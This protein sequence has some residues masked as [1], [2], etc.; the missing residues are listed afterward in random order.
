MSSMPDRPVDGDSRRA[1]AHGDV[2]DQ[3]RRIARAAELAARWSEEEWEMGLV[4]AVLQPRQ[5]GEDT[6]T[7]R[8]EY[9]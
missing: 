5:H 7:T 6:D 1:S 9:Q 8:A 4:E 2:L 3:A